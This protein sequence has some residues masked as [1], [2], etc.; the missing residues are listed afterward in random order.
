MPPV[1]NWRIR[2]N[3][4]GLLVDWLLVIGDSGLV[5]K[6]LIFCAGN[7]HFVF[8]F[9]YNDLIINFL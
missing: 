1:G 7:Q 5:G 6:V 2:S 8:Y 4:F 9:M 3:F